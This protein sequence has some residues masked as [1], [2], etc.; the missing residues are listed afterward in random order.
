M[1]ACLIL[2][3][4]CPKLGLERLDLVAHALVP[5]VHLAAK[6]VCQP[7][8]VV[9]DRQQRATSLAHAQL[10]LLLAAGR[11]QLL[12]LGLLSESASHVLRMPLP[13]PHLCLCSLPL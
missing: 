6:V 11:Q 3:P 2:L 4:G 12:E 7:T 5:S 9:E 10:L 8:V 13:S 1:H